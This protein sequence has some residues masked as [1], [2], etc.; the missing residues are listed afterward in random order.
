MRW[1]NHQDLSYTLLVGLNDNGEQDSGE[2]IETCV[3]NIT[4]VDNRPVVT[5]LDDVTLECPADTST[6]NT[7]VGTAT[8]D[9]DGVLTPMFLVS[10][11]GC[12]AT[13]TITRTWWSVSDSC[14]QSD[15]HDQIITVIDTMPPS[16]DFRPG[17]E[18]FECP[19]CINVTCVGEAN[20]TRPQP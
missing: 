4:I 8:D 19:A 6:G 1:H 2:E 18:I 20:A 3:Q 14:E 7:G 15:S 16:F 10:A 5:A 12:G 17:D 11:P 9:C 13:E